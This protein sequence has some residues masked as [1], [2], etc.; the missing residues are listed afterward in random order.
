[1]KTIQD[2][3][4]NSEKIEGRTALFKESEIKVVGMSGVAEGFVEGKIEK[5][6]SVFHFDPADLKIKE[7]S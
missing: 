7:E 2:L 1:M 3:I 6:G 4:D 5:T